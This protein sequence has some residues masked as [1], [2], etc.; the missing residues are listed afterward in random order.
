MDCTGRYDDDEDDDEEDE[1]EAARR[2]ALTLVPV[3]LRPGGQEARLSSASPPPDRPLI[4]ILRHAHR[5]FA[6]LFAAR[7]YYTSHPLPC[8]AS[9]VAPPPCRLVEAPPALHFE[10]VKC[11]LVSI[12]QAWREQGW[13]LE[14]LP[15]CLA[16]VAARAG[17]ELALQARPTPDRTFRAE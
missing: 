12:A 5:G 14:L 7:A 1:D 15:G 10:K 6:S 13:R 3:G 9:S 16:G 4:L 17:G 2:R 8:P 11:G